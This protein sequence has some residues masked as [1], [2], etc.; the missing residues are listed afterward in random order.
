MLLS[1]LQER[2]HEYGGGDGE[3]HLGS[4]CKPWAVT[5]ASLDAVGHSPILLTCLNRSIPAEP[6]IHFDAN[7]LSSRN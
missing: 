7:Q 4:L 1:P 5:Q 3:K 6:H 2:N